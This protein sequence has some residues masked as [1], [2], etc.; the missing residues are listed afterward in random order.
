MG[1]S[2]GDMQTAYNN[3]ASGTYEG[4]PTATELGA[5]NIGGMTLG[6]GVYKWS[7]SL[8]IP[9]SV[10]LDAY[11][12]TSAIFVFQISQQLNLA[13]GAQVILAGGAQ[14][15]NIFW[16]VSTQATLGTTSVMEGTILAGT[17]IV[18]NN[19][20]TL[21]GRALAQSAVSLTGT[22]GGVSLSVPLAL[23]MN[24]NDATNTIINIPAGKTINVIYTPTNAILRITSP[25]NVFSDVAIADLTNNFTGTSTPSENNK[26]FTKV[27]ILNFSLTNAT[28]LG[29]SLTENRVCG[30]N[31][32]PYKYNS[33]SATWN[34]IPLIS[35][36][37]CTLT[38]NIPADP[39][40][41]TFTNSNVLNVSISASPTL[42]ATRN[43]GQTET[44]NAFVTGGTGP[45]TYNFA[46]YNSVT[47]I[48]V[49]N[50]FTATN[51]FAYLIPS[52]EL[53][54]TLFANVLVSDS[55]SN[56]LNSTHSGILTVAAGNVV[57]SGGGSPTL[58]V[59]LV[60]GNFTVLAETPTLSTGGASVVGN[61]GISPCATSCITGFGS[62][63]LVMN[64]P[65]WDFGEYATSPLVTGKVYG[66]DMSGTG[67]SAGVTPTMLTTATTDMSNAYTQTQGVVTPAPVVNVGAGDLAGLTLTPGVYKFTTSVVDIPSGTTLILNCQG[68]SNATFIFQMPGKFTM[69]SGAKVD[70]IG[71]CKAANIYWAVGTDAI[72]GTTTSISGIVMAG[73]SGQIVMDQGATFSGRALSQGEVTI[74]GTTG[75]GASSAG[76]N[77]VSLSAANMTV[78]ISGANSVLVG[79]NSN[80]TANV[81]NG[82]GPYTYQWS[83]NNAI[84]VT[85]ANVA[86]NS[87][88]YTFS[89][90]AT[91]LAGSPDLVKVLVT[92]S[93]KSGLATESINVSTT[94]VTTTIPSSTSSSGGGGG[95]GGSFVPTTQITSGGL[96]YMISNFTQAEQVDMSFLGTRFTVVE[97]FISPTDAG[98]TV[99]GASYTLTLGV[100]TSLQR[101]NGTN[102]TVELDNIT[103]IPI[104]HSITLSVCGAKAVVIPAAPVVNATN[105]TTIPPQ[106]P[107]VVATT[108]IA[109]TST[110][111]RTSTTLPVVA[112]NMNWLLLILLIVL[113]GGALAWYYMR[114]SKRTKTARK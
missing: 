6:P 43:V 74:V 90:N 55:L 66:A 62:L 99:N 101:V 13:N 112:S 107:A 78:S 41:G 100:A 19:G 44:F 97:N 86:A 21:N 103:Y 4:T 28:N 67:S 45:Y 30:S 49:A 35:A 114:S 18:I 9:T 76:I 91:T 37:S 15:K 11:G 83:I 80:L 52:S 94:P 20:A 56:S 111:G 65:T 105:S 68:N 57:V 73:P 40:I 96:C 85:N 32:V 23:S 70:L 50:M 95:T 110:V 26:V 54:N 12:N 82:V 39:V 2:I 58:P 38:F 24:A 33:I 60:A 109:A 88:T 48:Q 14:A 53:G 69:E 98:V 3:A 93:T 7:S 42:P 51:S 8:D 108:T 25:T 5:G 113:A 63:P 61:I 87:N 79:Q 75:T 22:T 106:I 89:G 102:Y 31:A 47:D 64:S 92:N 10:T 81:I 59:L 29:Y 17:A 36:T 34:A 1:I 27:S 72:F 104:R 84:V 46:I 16:Q 77:N 71:N